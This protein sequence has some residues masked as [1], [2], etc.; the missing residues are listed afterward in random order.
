MAKIIRYKTVAA[1]IAAALL[2]AFIG[3]RHFMLHVRTTFAREQLDVFMDMRDRALKAEPE[4]SVDCLRYLVEYYP[5]G[6]KQIR[7]SDLDLMVEQSRSEMIRQIIA[8]LR[9]K[10]GKDLGPS[11]ERWIAEFGTD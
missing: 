11:H 4:E 10:T 6:T 5:T 1:F 3:A 9:R 7:G 2:V 8:D